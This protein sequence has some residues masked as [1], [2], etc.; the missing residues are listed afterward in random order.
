MTGLLGCLHG[1]LQAGRIWGEIPE[2]PSPAR[3]G[4]RRDTPSP[5]KRRR[6]SG[7]P[8]ARATRARETRARDFTPSR[9]R[10]ES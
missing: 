9:G 8:N 5:T 6:P 2:I 1:A 7:R 4:S 10:C 3:T